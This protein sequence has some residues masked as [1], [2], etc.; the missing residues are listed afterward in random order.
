MREMAPIGEMA[1]G[2]GKKKQ[3]RNIWLYFRTP[4]GE[5][6]PGAISTM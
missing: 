1:P 4:I 3:E 2:C 5:M 6:A